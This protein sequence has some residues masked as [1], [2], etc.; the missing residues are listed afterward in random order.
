MGNPERCNHRGSAKTKARKRKSA[1][2][3]GFQKGT[4]IARCGVLG[5]DWREA[6]LSAYFAAAE[7]HT[8][9][10]SGG[11]GGG[12]SGAEGDRLRRFNEAQGV[13]K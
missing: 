7:A 10:Q 11:N 4:V 1:A 2:F 6:S 9:S 8:D 5:L 13:G 3:E 12:L